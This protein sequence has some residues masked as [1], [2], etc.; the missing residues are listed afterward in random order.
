[1][2]FVR[3]NQPTNLLSSLILHLPTYDIHSNLGKSF[4]TRLTSVVCKL[5]EGIVRDA[6]VAHMKNNWLF[7]DDQHGFRAGRSCTTQLLVTLEHWTS[8][9]DEGHVIDAI[10]FDLKK[11][12]DSVAHQSLLTK[13][14]ILWLR[15]LCA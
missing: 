15:R 2:S 6:V 11:A 1:M 8:L 7:S 14:K 12:F 5:L 3:I 9:L 10:H 13:L 4:I